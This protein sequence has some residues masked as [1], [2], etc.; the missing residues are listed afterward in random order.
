MVGGRVNQ[1]WVL[2]SGHGAR[3]LAPQALN[4]RWK[5]STV[6]RVDWWRWQ[7]KV[8]GAQRR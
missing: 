5:P 4:G 6:E 7:F 8:E 2:A 3:V 1:Q